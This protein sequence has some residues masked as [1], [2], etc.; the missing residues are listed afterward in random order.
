M[1]KIITKIV[2][3]GGPCAGK[4]TALVR[5]IEKFSD[6][7]YLI[8]ALPEAATLFNQAGVNFLT[9]DK[10]LFYAA[11]K[12]LMS[13]QMTME[14]RFADIAQAASRPALI[15]CDRGMMDISAYLTEESWQ[16]LL[17][18]SGLSKVQVRDKRYDA[19][20]HLTTAAK[21][22]ERHEDIQ[23]PPFIKVVEDVTDNKA[24]YN[25]SLARKK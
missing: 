17:D 18:E 16:A 3:T 6:L 12:S 7:G 21:G 23:F 25:N 10:S 13:F 1:E 8:L 5:I 2:L 19:V 14:D 24:F 9:P 22:A 15:I 11:E 4:T 20:L